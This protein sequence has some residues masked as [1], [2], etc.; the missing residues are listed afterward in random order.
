MAR[1]RAGQCARCTN[2]YRTELLNHPTED[3]NRAWIV[4]GQTITLT[5][6]A[7][8]SRNSSVQ[9]STETTLLLHPDSEQIRP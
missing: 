2:R 9:F 1:H 5:E 4:M 7:S 6:I 3:T 8:E